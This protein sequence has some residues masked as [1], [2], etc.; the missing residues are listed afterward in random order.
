MFNPWY[1]GILLFPLLMMNIVGSTKLI[2]DPV[3]TQAKKIV[4]MVVLWAVPIIGFLLVR[5]ALGNGW[6]IG[7][8]ND[9]EKGPP[10]AGDHWG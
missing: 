7:S 3:F 9:V 1:L 8:E 10:P 6:A 4:W 2:N 5:A